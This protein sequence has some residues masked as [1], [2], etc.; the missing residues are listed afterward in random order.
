MTGSPG[1]GEQGL[2]GGRFQ[3]GELLGSGGS[4]AV[5]RCEDFG[6][7]DEQGRPAVVALK[8]L[9]PALSESQALR[10]AFLREA[11]RLAEVNQRN[12]A[13]VYASGLRDTGATPRAWIA[14]EAVEG[15]TVAEWVA[16]HGPL[17]PYQAVAVMDGLLSGLQ[18]AHDAG[19][20]HRDVAPG[21]VILDDVGPDEVISAEAVRLVDFGLSDAAD[22][23]V[24]GTDVLLTEGQDT[25]TTI[26]GSAQYLSPEQACGSGVGPA[27]DIYQAGAVLYFLL[28]GQPPFVRATVA[29]SVQARLTD[30]P[31]VPS[32]VEASARR[33]DRVVVKALAGQ[34][35]ARYASAEEF[36]Q[37]LLAAVA[38][39]PG[40]GPTRVM[41]ASWAAPSP[42]PGRLDLPPPLPVPE[43]EA[44]SSLAR[45]VVPVL[46]GALAVAVVA[47]IGLGM[48]D[49]GSLAA[50][51]MPTV[52]SASPTPTATPTPSPRQDS[53][54]PVPVQ[55][56]VPGLYGDLA[57]AQSALSAAGLD[58]GRVRSRDSGEPSGRVLG[59]SPASGTMAS[60][61]DTVDVTL[62]SGYNRVPAVAGMTVTAAKAVL[63]SA[64]FT[65]SV[66]GLDA[67]AIVVDSQPSAHARLLLGVTVAVVVGP[68][69]PVSPS[70]TPS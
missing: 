10:E 69:A 66:D 40:D 25:A 54:T 12:V 67:A 62:A 24:I 46:I 38:V 13:A 5:Y 41:A 60:P 36:R 68:T 16:D 33:L 37:S 15:P 44:G 31:P 19:L 22:R 63:E 6:Q 35:E 50:A 3:I 43:S 65:V 17:G 34:P 18:A 51:P 32:A 29:H 23:T 59:Q 61:G 57:A 27:S 48:A 58:I 4:A 53:A 7:L 26:V 70:P 49:A 2:F 47:W 1:P 45:L 11:G 30:P 9:H 52:G 8:V 21:N 28:T 55:V 14:M 39:R 20:M 64:G 42:A 56:R